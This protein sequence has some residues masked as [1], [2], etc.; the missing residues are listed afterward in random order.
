MY[1]A[2][3]RFSLFIYCIVTRKYGTKMAGEE[4]AKF[5]WSTKSN[6]MHKFSFDNKVT[7]SRRSVDKTMRNNSGRE[8]VK[9]NKCIK[10]SMSIQ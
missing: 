8:K 3:F 5:L 7:F 1:F 9:D 4:S 10:V 2:F 6:P